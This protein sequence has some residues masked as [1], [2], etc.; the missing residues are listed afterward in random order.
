MKVREEIKEEVN[1][2][3][4]Y[5]SPEPADFRQGVHNLNRVLFYTKVYLTKRMTEDELTEMIREYKNTLESFLACSELH[6]D[7]ENQFREYC[8]KRNKEYKA[9]L[10]TFPKVE[11][12]EDLLNKI[13]SGEVGKLTGKQIENTQEILWDWMLYIKSK[14]FPIPDDSDNKHY[15][16]EPNVAS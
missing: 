6:D 13:F 15:L 2:L 14:D 8:L 11:E 12:V 5:G 3:S 1:S 10:I 4:D 16:T 9:D 7:R